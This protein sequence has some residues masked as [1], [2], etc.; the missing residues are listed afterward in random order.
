VLFE[1]EAAGAD[2]LRARVVTAFRRFAR[3]NLAQ[4][5]GNHVGDAGHDV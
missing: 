1:D 3:I 4:L 2:L 5:A